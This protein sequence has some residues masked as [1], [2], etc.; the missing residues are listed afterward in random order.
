MFIEALILAVILGY[1]LKGKLRNLEYVKIR[2]V[3]CV[4]LP[5]LFEAI[6]NLLV[7]LRYIHPSFITLI[8]VIA[9]YLFLLY[10][11]FLNR[12]NPF[13]LIM[14]FGFLL[15]GIVIII[16]GGVMPVS[17]NSSIMAGSSNYVNIRNIGLYELIDSH[18]KLWVLG[19]IFPLKLGLKFIFSIGDVFISLGLILF[20]I[21]GMKKTKKAIDL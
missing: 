6:M 14:G 20:T 16:N 12:K 17:Y 9:L 18:T 8:L 3:Y 5:F 19:D 7:R 21:T 2:G 10:F 13:I 15:N 4:I 11:T 1:L